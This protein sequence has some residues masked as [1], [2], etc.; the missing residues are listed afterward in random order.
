[1][2]K[3]KELNLISRLTKDLE[4]FLGEGDKETAEF[5][6]NLYKENSSSQK[7]TTAL[8]TIELPDQLIQILYKTITTLTTPTLSNT[9]NNG[10]TGNRVNTSSS[11]SNIH[12]SSLSS[13]S[14]QVSV[15]SATVNH[16]SSSLS[17]NIQH[18]GASNT[19]HN[20]NSSSSS[21]SLPI[22]SV[23]E[24]LVTATAPLALDPL[25]ANKYSSL[26]M[27]NF[28]KSIPLPDF[29]GGGTGLHAQARDLIDDKLDNTS[30]SHYAIPSHSQSTLAHST[31]NS[32]PGSLSREQTPSLSLASRSQPVASSSSSSSSSSQHYSDT[33][34]LYG[35]YDGK[36]T[37]IKDF[38]CFVELLGFRNKIEGLVHI[39]QISA[40]KRINHPSEAVTRGQQVK[41]KLISIAGT[42]YSLS[43]KDV[44]QI[45]GT[46]L[47]PNR[48]APALDLVREKSTSSFLSSNIGSMNSSLSSTLANAPSSRR[49]GNISGIVVSNDDLNTSKKRTKRLSSPERFEIKQLIASGVLDPSDYP[50]ID[51]DDSNDNPFAA[52]A[53]RSKEDLD[54]QEYEIEVADIEPAFLSGQ[55]R[56]ARELSP[57]KLVANPDGTMQRAAMNQ[58]ALARE[59][60]EI[61]DQQKQQLL[62]AIPKDLGRAWADPTPQS[63]ERHLA[64]DLR[65]IS[66]GLTSVSTVPEW[67]QKQNATAV[68]YGQRTSKSMKEQRETL[69]I[70]AMRDL[71]IQAITD[72]QVLV[73]V[74]ETGSG[75]T[76]QMTQYL[77]EAGFTRRGI[78]GCTQ[79]RRVAAISIAKRVAEEMGVRLSEEV[80]YSVRFDDMTSP[81]T[82]IKYM[83]DGML[84]REYLMDN[85][86]S[87]YS[88]LMLDE[89]HERTIN[90]DILFGL[91]KALLR[92]R[93]D[94]KLIV[95]SATLDAE[96][97]ANYFFQCNILTIPGRT[98]KV[99][100]HFVKEPESDYLD[101]ALIAV[102]QIHLQEPPGDI[103]VFLT[104]QEEIEYACETLYER[105]KALENKAPE[106]LVLPVY[107]ALPSEMQTKIFEPAPP[108]TRKCIVA[109]NIAEAS[110]TLD[111]IYYVVDPGFCKQKVFN[112]K[113]GMDS[114]VVVPISQA[115][116]RQRAGRAGR[117]G[118]GVCYRLYTEAAFK[119][120]MQP[121]SVPEIQ[122]ANLANVVLQLK[123][124]GVNDLLHFDFMDPPSPQILIAALNQLYVLGALDDEGLLTRLG[125]KMAEFPL[126]PQ[127]AKVLLASVDLGCSEEV[128]TIVAMLSVENVF[129]R[130]KDQ[131]VQADKKRAR[132]YQTEGDHITFLA[133]YNAWAAAQFSKPW[134]HENFIQFRAIQHARDVRKQLLG[135]MDRYKLDV[136]SAGKNYKVV[137]KAIASGYFMNVAKKDPQEG[138]K[139]VVDNQPV[140]IHPSST[141]FQQN[142]E[143]VLYNELVLT[144]KEY[145]R[146]VMVVDPRWLVEVAPRFYQASDP[147][148][149]SKAKKRMKIEPLF[150]KY[151]PP[152]IWR[153]SKRK[154]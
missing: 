15:N 84:L 10:I 105:M 119:L 130:P 127:L 63:G 144:S 8:K 76:T 147:N 2:D 146:G 28:D 116:A 7:F 52:T 47:L 23:N 153:L 133:V 79:P 96:K 13:S 124:M 53:L 6:Y 5:I 19:K 112:P 73:V 35:I 11:S 154:G 65:G 104:G 115:S 131:N 87:K 143:M 101:A 82:L 61:K 66:M 88:V 95:T 83:T 128:L 103:L 110:L 29:E 152:D 46:D 51:G 149:M 86:L 31:Y 14:V 129:V 16:N 145:M 64:A 27:P 136:V 151:N 34:E 92:T 93:P 45:N 99:E 120:E 67:K 139:T 97:F 48:Q 30:S 91:L 57:V 125:R 90:T 111:G 100:T 107:S 55:T 141:I 85:K 20:T 121:S 32:I 126:D 62:D 109:T 132:F 49:P 1:M 134:C 135:I 22:L 81:S 113:T 42:K 58:G 77:H 118:P 43:I 59:R 114:L 69:P 94:L 26:S 3:L 78:I 140:Y 24:A 75:K 50:D 72:N 56:F 98:F 36:V 68:S 25:V 41:V 40:G 80:G 142:P 38:G 123:A 137:Q 21:S 54:E 9:N 37:N 39:S 71:I 74:G 33:P 4:N 102:M 89:A 117:T 138:Y 148:R 108:G 122:R 70:F 150:D 18:N 60:K 44:D 17:S 106:L 12:S